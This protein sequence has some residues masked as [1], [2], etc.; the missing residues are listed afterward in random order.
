MD[1]DEIAEALGEFQEKALGRIG[2]VE[3]KL[4]DALT[5]FDKAFGEIEK[6]TLFG[7]GNK[8][9]GDS[10][11]VKAAIAAGVKELIRG[12]QSAADAH[13]AKAMQQMKGTAAIAGEDPA[14]G[15]LVGYTVGTMQS[16][17]AQISPLGAMSRQIPLTSGTVFVEPVDREVATAAWVSEQA[18]RPSTAAPRLI[19]FRCEAFEMYAAPKA[20]QLLIDVADID[21]LGWLTGKITEGFGVLED[22]SFFNGDGVNKPRGL[23]TIP[24]SAQDD[25]ARAWGTIQYVKTGV[26]GDFPTPSATVGAGDPLVDLVMSLKPMYRVNASW[27]M[28]RSTAAA[29][30]KL[31]DTTGRWLWTDSLAAGEPDR[32]L[33][34]PVA[35]SESMPAINTDTN[36]IAFGDFKR[37]YTVVRKPGIRLLSDP[38]TEKPYTVLY[39]RQLVGG[40]VANTEA[41]KFLRF[42]D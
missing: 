18:P 5:N 4:A 1:R 15:V 14:G 17:P 20:S 3:R 37:A 38:F 25:D 19:E 7:G 30:R 13:F 26:D 33:G 12:N 21:V 29:V 16:I 9:N 10:P 36:S 35:L 34:F 28:S 6:R 24:T 8:P 22:S 27:M 31:R 32:L 23:L 41:V 40:N 42:G 11:E 39:A 2:D